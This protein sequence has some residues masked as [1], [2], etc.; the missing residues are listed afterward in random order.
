ME[1][2]Q[3]GMNRL[4]NNM[5]QLNHL[6]QNFHTE[7]TNNTKPFAIAMTLGISMWQGHFG[8][9]E[10][11]DLPQKLQWVLPQGGSL[12]KNQSDKFD[13]LSIPSTTSNV[14]FAMF[15]PLKRL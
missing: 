14:M 11:F 1:I 4:G 6:K 13:F 7:G 10:R 12:G 2:Y 3:F 8:V 15:Q 5:Q 9:F